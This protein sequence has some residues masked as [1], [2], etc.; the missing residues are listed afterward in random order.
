MD[1]RQFLGSTAATATLIAGAAPF[2]ARAET[3]DNQLAVGFSM[4]NILTLDPAGA[5]SKEKVQVTTNIY[6]GLVGIDPADRSQVRG[7]LAESWEIAED[8]S[9]ITFTLRPDLKFASGNPLEAEDVIWSFTRVLRLNLAQA[10]NFTIRGYTA[11]AAETLFEAPD[12]RTVVVN[13]PERTDPQIILMTLAIAGTGAVLDRA[14][15]MEHEVDGD[16]GSAWLATNTA[17]SGPF[18]LQ[19]YR[20]GDLVVLARNE[21]Y[22]G[23]P[24]NMDRVLMRHIP[25]SQ[26]QRLLLEQGDLDV[27]Y[28]LSAADLGSLESNPDVVVTNAVGN[29][30][31]YLAMS[32]ADETLQDARVR[33]AI[34]KLI[35]YDGINQS[36]MQYY[37]VKHTSP[38][39]IGLGGETFD[40]SVERDVEGAKELLAEA[41]YQ[42][43]LDLT[44]R[45]LSESPFDN[46]AVAVQ[47]ALA[48]GGVRA[49]L[50]TGGGEIVY[51]AM[52]NR[53]FQLLVGRSGGQVSHPDGDLRSI[54]Y[55]PDN[56][57]D[58][59]LTGLLS[60]RVSYHDAAINS[61]IAE[62]LELSGDTQRE[63]YA[64][65]QREYAAGAPPIQPISQVTDSVATRADVTGLTISPVWQTKLA[66]VGKDR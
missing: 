21:N 30:L 29:G 65:I 17:G 47:G 59:N 38:I 32:L 37:G 3:P 27:A 34:I 56:S 23:E 54:V 41:G 20:P 25:E 10:T 28:S 18:E 50:I 66:S 7:E 35:D 62:A 48:E 1:R 19:T 43:G 11:D 6:D 57:D 60:W 45:A 26:T 58:A 42:D 39:Q 52:R 8:A 61:Q 14:T 12:P 33:E 22:W 63:A 46:L 40:S 51:G 4:A 36:V 13:I 31:Y 55:N 64:E 44:L 9:S 49:Q 16:L 24:A 15:V 2:A 53:D 5:G